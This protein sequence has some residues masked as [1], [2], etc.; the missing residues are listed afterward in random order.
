MDY[1][2]LYSSLILEKGHPHYLHD[3]GKVSLVDQTAMKVLGVE[4]RDPMIEYLRV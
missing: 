1:Y 2:F 4:L 3:L